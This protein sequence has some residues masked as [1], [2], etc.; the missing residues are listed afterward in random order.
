MDPVGGNSYVSFRFPRAVD[1]SSGTFRIVLKTK[2]GE[3]Y[4][5]I[6]K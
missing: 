1:L 5:T 6:C 4:L 2:V 3:A